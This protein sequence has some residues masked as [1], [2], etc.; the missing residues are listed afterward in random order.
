MPSASNVETAVNNTERLRAW[1][2]TCP[3]IASG[4]YFGADYIGE[5]ATEYALIS[6]PSMLRY[7]ENIIGD[8]ILLTNQEQNFIFAARVPYGSDVQQNL[9]NL[10]FLREVA[11][12]IQTQSAAGNFPDWEGGV[13]TAIEASN[14]AAPVQG[15]AVA[16]RYQFQIRVAY[17][18]LK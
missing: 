8:R 1:L 14:T 17:K 7:R 16:A 18:V 13:I 3:T 4:K 11:M 2:R 6:S 9:D 15:G 10:Q 5:N 12:W